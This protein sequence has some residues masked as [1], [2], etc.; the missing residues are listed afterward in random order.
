VT[1]ALANHSAATL[2]KYARKLFDEAT[3]YFRSMPTD[4]S[5]AM[6]RN[7]SCALLLASKLYAGAPHSH[8][9][10]AANEMNAYARRMTELNAKRGRSPF[11][12]LSRK[13]Q[14]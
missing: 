1:Q 13:V 5:E 6:V 2:V 14:S 10:Y 9:Q 3:R 7:A 11:T 4:E 12:F 8:F